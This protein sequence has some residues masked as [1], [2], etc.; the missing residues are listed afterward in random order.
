MDVLSLVWNVICVDTVDVTHLQ[1]SCSNASSVAAS[2]KFLKHTTY[3][4]IKEMYEFIAFAVET[5]GTWEME[6]KALVNTLDNLLQQKMGAR[7]AQ[8]FLIQNLLRKLVSKDY[9]IFFVKVF[10]Y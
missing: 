3:L 7:D 10:Y 6:P 2:L 1:G 4:V 8:K 9:I 5:F